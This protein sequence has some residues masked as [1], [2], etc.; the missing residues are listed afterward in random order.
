MFAVHLVER[1]TVGRGVVAEPGG[2]GDLASLGLDRL[3][4]GQADLV[5]LARVHLERRPAADRG[6]IQLLAVGR[7]P[8][9][10]LLA[11][12]VAVLAAERLEERRVGRV[13][14]VAD[15][16]ADPLAVG[17]AGALDAARDDRLVDRDGEHPLELG[18][19]PLGHD[20]RGG[21]AGAERLLEDVGV[22]LP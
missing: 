4:L 12:G 21:Q 7:R 14:L 1:G 15:D 3:E 10:R 13:D 19:R 11:A 20:R 6:P 9:A 2:P 8:D 17:V 18:D 5:D 22:G 16:V